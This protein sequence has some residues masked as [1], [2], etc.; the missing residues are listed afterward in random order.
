MLHLFSRVGI[1]REVLTHQGPNFMSKTLSQVYDLLGIKRVRTIPYHP[2]TDGLVERFNQTLVN[3][4]R[5]FVDDT[6]KDWDQ[7]LPY[8]LFALWQPDLDTPPFRTCRERHIPP[9][10]SS[11]RQPAPIGRGESA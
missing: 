7:W 10:A 5:K 11:R 6:G 4:P 9:L 8:L 1:P 2:Q 3:M